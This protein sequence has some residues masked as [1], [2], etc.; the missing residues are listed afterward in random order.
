[1]TR[2]GAPTG[3]DRDNGGDNDNGSDDGGDNGSD[4]SEAKMSFD[5]NDGSTILPGGVA[6]ETLPKVSLHDHLDG[7]LRPE[8]I[9]ELALADPE[10]SAT[11]P[12]SDPSA[13]A[14]WFFMSCNA[15]SLPDYLKTFDLTV[16]VMQTDAQLERVAREWVLDIAAEG[17]IYGETRWA[18]EQHLRAGLTLDE[19]VEAVQR[20]LDA[21]VAEVRAAGVA[22]SGAPSGGAVDG[23]EIRV[24][25]VLCAMRHADRSLE[26]AE[27]ALRHRDAGVVGFDIAGAEH[28]FS[29]ALHAPAFRLLAENQFPATVHAGEADGL[30]SIT[31]ALVDG[32]ALRLGHGVR[33]AEDITT[34]SSSDEAVTVSLGTLAQWVKDRGITLELCPSSNLQ[35]GAIAQWGDTLAEHPFDLFYQLGM[36]V[37]VNPDNR[38]MSGTSVSRELGLLADE[39]GYR[40]DDLEQFQVNAAMAAF[41]S[42]EDRLELVERIEQGFTNAVRA[43]RR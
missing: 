35:T 22:R 31:S 39:F 28:G 15:G 4:G 29:A 21:G 7:A 9:I 27:L 5:D 30:A 24:G 17:I 13:L 2:G 26:I 33:L 1:M 41:I 25:Q 43:T 16:S 34:E 20:G 37:T 19:A 12:S 38:L 11:L 32:Y 10:L 42:L 3:R 36:A 6:I 40:L 18:P 8:T 14:D 23:G